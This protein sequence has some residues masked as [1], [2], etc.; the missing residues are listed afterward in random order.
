MPTVP[1]MHTGLTPLPGE[2]GLASAD[3]ADVA[4]LLDGAWSALLGMARTVDLDAPTRL[5]GWSTRDVLVHLGSWDGRSDVDR[6]EQD[7]RSAR[8]TTSEDVDARN[9]A[10]VAEHRDASREEVLAALEAARRRAT[11]FLSD[12]DVETL[13]RRWVGSV[14]G[15]LPMTGLLVAQGYELAVHALDLATAGGGP[16]PPALLDAG[17]AA[18]VDVT[19]ALAAR[20]DMT[21][22][23]AVS[24]P[25]GQWATGS[26]DGAWTTVRLAGDRPVRELPWPG[27]TGEAADVLDAVSGRA[28]AAQLLLTRR[29]RVHDVPGLLRLLPA[30]EAVPGL[31]GGSVLQTTLG[32]LGQTGRL[33]GR[34]GGRVGSLLARR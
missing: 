4:T 13:G 1:G 17:V 15:D 24:T 9:A 7:L 26:A 10:L 8:V 28:L 23:F 25:T 21:V 29:L 32:A 20:R 33:A 27:V 12:P 3:P 30:L 31:P 16:V 5:E 14:V 2:R 6:H 11:T 18:V 19:G 22:S 34:I